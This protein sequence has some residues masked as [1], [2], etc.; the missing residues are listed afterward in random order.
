MR[1]FDLFYSKGFAHLTVFPLESGG[2]KVYAD[3][4]V[5]R[6]KVLGIPPVREILIQ[7]V[8]DQAAGEPVRLVA[9]PEGEFLSVKCKVTLD[10]EAMTAWIEVTPPKTGGED[11]T[12]DLLND[13]LA[14]KGVVMGIKDEAVRRIVE[15]L[16]YNRRILV[17]QGVLPRHGQASRVKYHFVTE[18][19]PYKELLYGRIDLKE[20]NYVQNRK[21]GDLL[22]E[23]TAAENP[24]DGYTVTGEI[25]SAQPAGQGEQIRG[26]INTRK[27]EDRLY[28]AID[29]NARIEKNEVI[30]E[31]VVTLKNVDYETGNIDFE[32]SVIVKGSVADGFSIKAGG[33]IETE[34]CVGRVTL[35]AG[36]S[37]ILKQGVNG[38]NEASL[39]AGSNVV[40]K[41]IESSQVSCGG[42]LLVKEA[43]MHSTVLVKGNLILSGGRAELLGGTAI[44]Y[45][46]FWCRKLGGLYEPA[47][48]I[49]IG[50]DP[51]SLGEYRALLTNIEAKRTRLDDLDKKIAL[52]RNTEIQ[53]AQKDKLVQAEYQLE[54]EVG[55]LNGEIQEMVK[56]S[57]SLKRES[58]S[59]AGSLLVAEDRIYTGVHISF[60][61]LDYMGNSGG[62]GVP[63]TIIQR[64]DDKLVEKGFNPS[65]PPEITPLEKKPND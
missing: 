61:F 45:G 27:E 17:A 36:R 26:G 46:S 3:D 51:D 28:A 21:E 38:D 6:M 4:I 19:I 12:L 14:E 34:K 1:G 18:R 40:A 25:L 39:T 5:N 48:S 60:G 32:G 20:L 64:V 65:E 55:Q 35:E 33:D 7:H 31:P 2:K 29:G 11:I 13:A 22:A 52:I 10:E 9:W 54:R 58:Q 24:V 49:I 30:V 15:G 8:L 43:I 23:L 62:K 56:K 37:I 47:T 41:Y 63:K 57:H 44:V 50:L 16:D 42:D 53:G 59:R